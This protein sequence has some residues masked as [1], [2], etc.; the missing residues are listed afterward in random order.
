MREKRHDSYLVSDVFSFNQFRFFSPI[1]ALYCQTQI[2][3]NLLF[4]LSFFWHFEKSSKIWELKYELSKWTSWLYLHSTH[5]WMKDSTQKKPPKSISRI[6]HY[7]ELSIWQFSYIIG[8]YHH[9]IIILHQI[10]CTCV[11]PFCNN[12]AVGAFARE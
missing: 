5:F 1:K 8:V 10:R 4:F 7:L 3:Q 12:N 6:H 2:R 9:D 11:K